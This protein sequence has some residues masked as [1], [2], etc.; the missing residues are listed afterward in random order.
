MKQYPLFSE[1]E[2][3]ENQLKF[4]FPEFDELTRVQN[5]VESFSKSEIRK[6]KR[7][8]K[9]GTLTGQFGPRRSKNE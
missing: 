5:S 2:L 9:L 7:L 4:I 6:T 8:E 3:D 1:D